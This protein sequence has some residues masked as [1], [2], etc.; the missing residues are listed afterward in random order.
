MFT[1]LFD[2]FQ[3]RFSTPSMSKPTKTTPKRQRASDSQLR[4]KH[5]YQHYN[6]PP[7]ESH[8]HRTTSSIFPE[9]FL[10]SAA[11]E[12]HH[13]L[14][15]MRVPF[16]TRGLQ[17]FTSRWSINFPMI[18]ARRL[19]G[20]SSLNLF[21]ESLSVTARWLEFCDFQAASCHPHYCMPL[22]AGYLQSEK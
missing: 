11:H 9:G 21:T 5:H 6:R 3:R 20:S 22:F 4:I 17:S 19:D 7:P 14:H 10:L 15:R 18:D 12:S 13:D 16:S 2:G 1:Y 8:N